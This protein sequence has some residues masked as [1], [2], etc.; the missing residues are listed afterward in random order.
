VRI[1]YV[2][3]EYPPAAHGGIGTVTR[4]LARALVRRGHEA[5]VVGIYPRS[6]HAPAY[7]KDQGVQ[8]WR[9]SRPDGRLG[10]VSARFHLF[11]VI[12][13]WCRAGRVDLVEVPDWE[14]WAA[15]WPRLPVPVVV[16]L[17][18]SVSYF[19]AELGQP[20]RSIAYHLERASLRR[21]DF[22]CPVSRYIALRTQTLFRLPSFPGAILYNPVEPPARRSGE[23][24]SS[25]Q[26]VFVGTLTPR[27]G[28]VALFKAWPR[29]LAARADAELHVFGKD[30][31][32]SGRSMRA[33]LDS[34]LEAGPARSVRFYGH[35]ENGAVL[36]ALARA[37]LA[38]FPSYAESFGLAPVEA[39]ACGCPTIY[40]RRG[41]GGEVIEDGRDGLLVDPDRPAEIAE[42]ILRLLTDDDLATRLA[43][44]G[45]AR[46]EGRFA[47]HTVL[48]QNESFYR[49]CLAAFSARR[50]QENRHALAG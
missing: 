17:H 45:F 3:H 38:V 31:R 9:L 37:R 49:Q 47:L 42:A 20:V 12:A 6:S 8:V 30:G 13:D 24:R 15:G 25:N 36:A 27:K 41:V 43:E 1:C 5:T 7:E 22:W 44:A 16:R 2:C 26:V 19:A 4:T 32:L 40:S 46:V 23:G 39:M 29:V 10:W 21:A 48:P 35:V 50:N 34:L 11:R 33:Y 18:G 28:I 14:G